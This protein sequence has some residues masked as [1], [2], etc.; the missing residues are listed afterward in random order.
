MD[1]N[2]ASISSF[3]SGTAEISLK[4]LKILNN[5]NNKT[6]ELGPIGMIDTSTIIVSNTFHP[7]LKKSLLLGS[8]INLI[9]ISKTKK[10]VISISVIKNNGISVSLISKVDA[11]IKKAEIIIAIIT[12]DWK[13]LCSLIL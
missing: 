9:I 6:D 4:T 2:S 7:L 12:I 5:L 8:A 1:R 3:N 13:I 10:S 11:P